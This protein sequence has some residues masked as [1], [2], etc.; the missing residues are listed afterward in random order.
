MMSELNYSELFLFEDPFSN[1]WLRLKPLPEFVNEELA[2]ILAFGSSNLSKP[3]VFRGYMGGPV[4][5]ILRTGLPPFL[6][7]SQRV[8]DILKENHFSGWSTYPV[9]VFDRKGNILLGYYG[10]AVTSYAGDRDLTRSPI[11]DKGP[12]VNGG[13]PYKIY[14]GFYFD[15]TKWDGSDVFRVGKG[16]IIVSKRVRDAFN[17]VKIGNVKFVALSDEETNTTI[18]TSQL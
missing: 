17:E 3:V 8:V 2:C 12:I 11:I 9:E 5:D 6:C 7:I 14:K 10:F 1:R 13:K 4:A 16:N 15:K 18:F